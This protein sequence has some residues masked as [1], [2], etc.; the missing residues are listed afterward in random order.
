LKK[1]PHR[2]VTHKTRRHCHLSRPLLLVVKESTTLHAKMEIEPSTGYNELSTEKKQSKPKWR[3]GR[4]GRKPSH[5]SRDYQRYDSER[6][7]EE[8]EEEIYIVRQRWGYCSILFSV[9]QTIILAIMM[10]KCGVAPLNVNPMVGPYPDVLSDWGGKNA[11]SILD[12]GEWW[13]LVTPILLHAGVIHLLCNVAVQLETGAFFE[14]EWGSPTWLTIY[15]VSAVGSSIL[16]VIAMPNSISVGSSGAVMG[17]FG[18][19]LS[20]ACLRFF[21]RVQCHQD[22]VAHKVRREQLVACLCSVLIVGLFSF[23]PYGE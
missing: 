6:F 16:S 22:H 23:I 8:E 14:R 17:L 20:E 15:L 1:A 13:R 18:G 12:D 2:F 9:V 7:Q 5:S 10:I 19:K 3:F 11:V 4:N 21:E